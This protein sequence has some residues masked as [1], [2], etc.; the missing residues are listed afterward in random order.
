MSEEEAI[1]A[2]MLGF[3][4]IG[5]LVGLAI[6]VFFLLTLHKCL[7]EVSEANRTMQPGMVWLNLVPLLNLV[8][9]FITVIKLSES[10]VAEGQA[11]GAQV[12]DGG[13]TIGLV[14]AISLIA[15]IIPF[16]GFLAA[17]V[18]LVTF[19]IYW[20]KVA[21]YRKALV[22]AQPAIGQV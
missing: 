5:L 15:S 20:V 10:V 11:R 9:I 3:G 18:A 14:Y 16:I 19:I 4:F 7:K 12:D 8:W 17:L 22:A 21:G 1:I 6:M 13:K 2:A